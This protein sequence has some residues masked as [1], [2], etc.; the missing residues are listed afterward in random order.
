[1]EVYTAED[2]G[3]KTKSVTA[4][5]ASSTPA[6]REPTPTSAAHQEPR[7]RSPHDQYWRQGSE[8]REYSQGWHRDRD[9][10]RASDSRG[11]QPTPSAPRMYD[12]PQ[13]SASAYRSHVV[14]KPYMRQAA[15]P[16]VEEKQPTMPTY[17][18]QNRPQPQP[19]TRRVSRSTPD[20]P[21]A[22]VQRTATARPAQTPLPSR[23]IHDSACVRSVLLALAA[24]HK[25]SIDEARQGGGAVFFGFGAAAATDVPAVRRR[26]GAP[27]AVSVR[28]NAQL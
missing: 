28:P 3:S 23:V 7:A 20:Q 19:P 6:A 15:T 8:R 17:R 4:Q 21:R 18:S 16:S 13:S 27:G 5:S 24:C 12:G 25:R 11:R 26:M 22:P 1:M 14:T 10:R 2:F 9:D